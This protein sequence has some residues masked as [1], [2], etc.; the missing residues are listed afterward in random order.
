MYTNSYEIL[1]RK[2]NV[3][4]HNSSRHDAPYDCFKIN[5]KSRKLNQINHSLYTSTRLYSH[6]AQR[7]RKCNDSSWRAVQ[8][9]SQLTRADVWQANADMDGSSCLHLTPTNPSHYRTNQTRTATAQ[10]FHDPSHRWPVTL[11]KL[12]LSTKCERENENRKTAGCKN[13]ITISG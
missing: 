12:C 10:T 4:A 8:N 11:S 6:S 2:T 7:C 3:L 13:C 1:N 9:I 5:Y